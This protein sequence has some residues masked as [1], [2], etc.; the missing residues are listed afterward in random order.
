[1]N[2][3][4]VRCYIDCFDMAEVA[5]KK[6]CEV[7]QIEEPEV[8]FYKT[9]GNDNL[10]IRSVFFKENYQI[11]FDSEALEVAHPFQIAAAAYHEARHAFQWQVVNDL[12]TGNE[13]VDIITKKS[14]LNDFMNYD[15]P[16]INKTQDKEYLSQA[17]EVDAVMFAYYQ[18]KDII[19]I[20]ILIPKELED[21][22]R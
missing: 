4:K 20:D 17:I 16:S 1:M 9:D 22:I 10:N 19:D 3:E 18:W 14:W 11:G 2:N 15:S 8:V 21:L 5:V 12:Y 13:V 7:L 6:A